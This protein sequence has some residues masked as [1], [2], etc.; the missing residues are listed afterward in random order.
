MGARYVVV[1]IHHITNLLNMLQSS[2]NDCYEI[3]GILKNSIFGKDV[4]C[5]FSNDYEFRIKK[6]FMKGICTKIF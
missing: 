3:L 4:H 5:T 6:I 1:Y 2:S